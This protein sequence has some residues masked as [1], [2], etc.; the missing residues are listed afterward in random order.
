MVVLTP[1]EQ[2]LIRNRFRHFKRENEAT[3]FEKTL[4]WYKRWYRELVGREISVEYRNAVR[5]FILKLESETGPHL[6]HERHLCYL[7]ES[8][9]DTESYKALIKNANFFCK[10]CGRAAAKE[11]NLCEPVPL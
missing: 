4:S 11:E 10:T 2:T 6:G 7:I 3:A 5:D 1:D 9:F 8:N